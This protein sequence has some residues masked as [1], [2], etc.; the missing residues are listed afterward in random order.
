M[1][2]V[3]RALAVLLLLA[4][5]A[6][7][8]D[9]AE[10]ARGLDNLTNIFSI[11][12]VL[13][14]LRALGNPVTE[15]AEPMVDP[16]GTPYKVDFA[17]YRIAGAGSDRKFDE[18]SWQTSEQFAGTEGDVVFE[19]SNF[20]RTNHNWLCAR[21]TKGGA[22]EN[23]L[24]TLRNAEA[25]FLTMR[26]PAMRNIAGTK[27][28]E[29]AIEQLAAGIEAYRDENRT[30]VGITT[31]EN[32]VDAWGVPLRLIIDGMRYRIIAAGSD[33]TFS[34]MTWDRPAAPDPAEDT[35]YQNRRYLRRIDTRAIVSQ[36]GTTGEPL[37]QPLEKPLYKRPSSGG[38]R[39]VDKTITAPVVESRVEPEY[40][41]AYRRLK[42]AGPVIVQA[43]I[44]KKGEI[45]DVAVLKS[46]G[47]AIDAA[48]LAAVRQ[49]KFKPGMIKGKP[50]PVF[51]D[52]TI[53]FTLN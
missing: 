45:E 39:R 32:A 7:M 14:V 12:Q 27:M 53:N 49:W 2:E 9:D 48:A 15:F 43:A 26:T 33:H 10:V 41:E 16:W 23:A 46:L 25:N 4:A 11:A 50:V 42:I 34:P 37:P 21:V 22:S 20:K 13:D 51:Y 5:P 3:R 1:A 36:S 24:A 47:P 8:A 52:L 18:A 29:A 6:A 19:G 35:I 30:L 38:H 40:P 17:A 44:S 31:P 28:S